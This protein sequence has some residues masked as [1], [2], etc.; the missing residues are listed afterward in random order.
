MVAARIKKPK[1]Q[2]NR[3]RVSLGWAY[4]IY[5]TV[6]PV[7]EYQSDFTIPVVSYQSQIS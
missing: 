7:P 5:S 2:I 4:P 3:Q 6:N 1:V